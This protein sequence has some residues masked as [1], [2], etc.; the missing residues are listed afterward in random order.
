MKWLAVWLVVVSS[1]V[2]AGSSVGKVKL[3]MPGNNV[4]IFKL[5]NHVN[6]PPCSVNAGQWALSLANET[7]KAQYALLLSA[8]AQGMVVEVI[9]S[10]TCGAWGDRE[11]PTWVSVQY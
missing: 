8:A 7:G 4:V 2:H 6:E 5:E 11:S 1:V 10:N 9:G 3:L